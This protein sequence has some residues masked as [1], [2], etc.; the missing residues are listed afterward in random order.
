M[1]SLAT[2]QKH[3]ELTAELVGLVLAK[4]AEGVFPRQIGRDLGLPCG[5]VRLILKA[6]NARVTSPDVWAARNLDH[7]KQL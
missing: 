4:R 1:T 3:I 5:L 2:E 7:S 6:H